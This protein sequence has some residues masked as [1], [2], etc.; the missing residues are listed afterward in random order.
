M[1]NA[2]NLMIYK[3]IVNL[4]N[5][6]ELKKLFCFIILLFTLRSNLSNLSYFFR[7]D[8]DF[9]LINLQIFVILIGL[10]FGSEVGITVFAPVTPT[11]E[12]D[13]LC[14]CKD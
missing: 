10:L 5:V 2:L 8:L 13:V 12:E 9:D 4:N 3:I 6:K 11:T 1:K 7:G 14:G